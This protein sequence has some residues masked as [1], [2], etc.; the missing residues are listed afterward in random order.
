[1]PHGIHPLAEMGEGKKIRHTFGNPLYLSGINAPSFIPI[2][3]TSRKRGIRM[4][5]KA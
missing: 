3:A 5:A 2:H 4:P 1:M